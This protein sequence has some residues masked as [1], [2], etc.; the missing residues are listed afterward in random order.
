MP[1]R[2]LFKIIV[3]FIFK[4]N[5]CALNIFVHSI[6]SIQLNYTV[7]LS[8]EQLH[9]EAEQFRKYIYIE[10]G[11]LFAIHTMYFPMVKLSFK[12]LWLWFSWW[13]LP[14]YLH[15]LRRVFFR[16]CS[17]Y[18]WNIHIFVLRWIDKNICPNHV[19]VKHSGE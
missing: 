8:S 15:D 18:Q 9:S 12:F 10:N 19:R 11:F 7:R 3:V 16:G 1:L 13:A 4:S 6:A 2:Q 17:S 14:K 5:S